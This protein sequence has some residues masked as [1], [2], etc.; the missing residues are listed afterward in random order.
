MAY[1]NSF[2]IPYGIFPIAQE[3]K[4]WGKISI[5]KLYVCCVS[6]L[7]LPHQSDINEYMQHTIILL[8]IEN[9]SK[10]YRHLLPD[11]APWLNL[12]ISSN[13]PSLEQITMVPKM[14]EPLKFDCFCVLLWSCTDEVADHIQ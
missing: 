10:N 13:Y 11:L 3:N 8:K 12:I 1:S 9:I 2:L 6:S 4:Y 14:F 7:E 5:M